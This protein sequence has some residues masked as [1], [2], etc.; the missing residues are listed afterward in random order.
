L[1]R[2]EP[3]DLYRA[4]GRR[5]GSVPLRNTTLDSV[6]GPPGG[7]AVVWWLAVSAFG[8]V[9]TTGLV[10]ALALPATAR[11]E[12]EEQAAPLRR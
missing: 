2:A 7:N 3:E 5:Q 10:I 6:R 12:R 1:G 9:V 11:W 8:F 4:A